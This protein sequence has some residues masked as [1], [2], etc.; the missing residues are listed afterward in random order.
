MKNF[1][2]FNLLIAFLAV[3][4]GCDLSK[5]PIDD[6]PV[7]KNDTRLLG[8]WREKEKKEKSDLYTLTKKSETS[9]LVTMKEYGMKRTL[10]YDAFLSDVNNVK[11]LNVLYKDDSANGYLFI[12]L[13]DINSSGNQT[14]AAAVS[15]SMMKYVSSSAA[16]RERVREN[17]NNPAFYSDTIHFEKVK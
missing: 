3:L 15:D 5:Y 10:K 11:F 13:L 2:K 9:Y 17:L 16:V 7:I 4:T 8:K 12:R 1:L 6:H 14:T